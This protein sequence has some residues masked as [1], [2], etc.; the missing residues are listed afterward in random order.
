[1]QCNIPTGYDKNNLC[2]F[3]INA[4]LL[5]TKRYMN[6]ISSQLFVTVAQIF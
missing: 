2:I 3:S 5:K 6:N 1:M 4:S